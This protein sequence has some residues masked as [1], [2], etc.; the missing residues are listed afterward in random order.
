MVSKSQLA[1][2]LSRLGSFTDPD[3]S[4]EQYPTD[5]EIA[6]DILWHAH[7]KG[8]IAGKVVADLGAGTGILGI[9]AILLGA[10][11]VFF[12]EKDKA[13][14]RILKKNLDLLDIESSVYQIA[15]GPVE[16][17]NRK[18][19]TV[20]MNPP[21]GTKKKHADRQF[22]ESAFRIASSII[23]FHK[24]ETKGFI[25]AISK[26]NDYSII[27][28]ID[29]DYPLKNTYSM[30]RLKKKKIRV[31]VFFFQKTTEES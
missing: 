3:I 17:F 30:H 5:S 1:I 24:T 22:L 4:V 26:D 7:M 13:A 29:Y 23:S 8:K 25:D 27:E 20:V 14:I 15:A 21:F 6:S 31:T 2:I 16:D 19:D 11:K 9:G 10:V 18:A 12:V 28:Q